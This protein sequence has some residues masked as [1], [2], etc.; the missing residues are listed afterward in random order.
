MYSQYFQIGYFP[1]FDYCE[2]IKKYDKNNFLY[3]GVNLLK[4]RMPE[5]VHDCPYEDRQLQVSN[6]TLTR[7]DF[8]IL[9]SG[10]YKVICTFSDDD[11][12]KIL[13]MITHLTV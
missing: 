3:L 11:D 10:K 2:F 8:A 7:S 6:L 4:K 12:N 13:K 1:K 9:P 5:S